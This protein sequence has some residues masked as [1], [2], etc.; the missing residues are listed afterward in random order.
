MATLLAILALAFAAAASA[1]AVR[2]QRTV[3]RLAKA[4]ARE[5]GLRTGPSSTAAPRAGEGP[6]DLAARE[7]WLHRSV[8]A[9]EQRLREVLARTADLETAPR[10]VAAAPAGA[11]RT[12][13]PDAERGASLRR[14]LEA[15]GYEDVALLPGRG[16]G[17]RLPFEARREG[18]PAKGSAT[19]GSDGQVEV[20]WAAAHRAFP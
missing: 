8:G 1:A 20:R 10:A 16:V 11:A 14:H 13:V 19:I 6:D 5:W 15:L 2:T 3:H 9:L 7:A 4:L 18:M 12:A 17:G